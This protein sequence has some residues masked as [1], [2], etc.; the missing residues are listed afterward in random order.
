MSFGF[1][2]Y[3]VHGDQCSPTPDL[4]SEGKHLF[5]QLPFKL[6]VCSLLSLVMVPLLLPGLSPHAPSPFALAEQT[7][8]EKGM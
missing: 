3:P 7:C 2:L 5:M 6:Q 1:G 4:G 8:V